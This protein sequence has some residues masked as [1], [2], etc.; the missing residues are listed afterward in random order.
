MQHVF[1]CFIMYF[2][3]KH[4]NMRLHFLETA[5]IVKARQE[6]FK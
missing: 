4:V 6:N 2:K 1:D 3:H 5:T